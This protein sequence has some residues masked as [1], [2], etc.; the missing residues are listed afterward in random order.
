MIVF[1][2]YKGVELPVLQSIGSSLFGV[3]IYFVDFLRF[4]LLY[5]YIY[6][7]IRGVNLFNNRYIRFV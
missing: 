7:Y 1:L 3:V 4:S 5:I 2:Q 6:I